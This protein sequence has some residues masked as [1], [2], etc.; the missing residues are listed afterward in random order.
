MKEPKKGGKAGLLY[1]AIISVISYL[2]FSDTVTSNISFSIET[3][4]KKTVHLIL[5]SI[6]INQHSKIELFGVL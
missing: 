1:L 5:L 6:S 4:N 2:S 3:I